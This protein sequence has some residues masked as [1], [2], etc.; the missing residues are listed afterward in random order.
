MG[1]Y[2]VVVRVTVG[3]ENAEDDTDAAEMAKN[4]IEFG[5][6]IEHM[7]VESIREIGE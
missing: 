3:V 5:M 6:N 7:Q 2:E 4:D 1:S